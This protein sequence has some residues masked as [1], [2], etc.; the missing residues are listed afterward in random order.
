MC[1]AQRKIGESEIAFQVM[2]FSY[3][4]VAANMATN[5]IE[6]VKFLEEFRKK[7]QGRGFQVI[8]MGNSPNDFEYKKAVL[9]KIIAETQGKSLDTV[10][11]PKIAAGFIWRCIRISASIR[12]CF[13]IRGSKQHFAVM[14]GSQ[15]FAKEVHFMEKVAQIKKKLTEEG[16]IRDDDAGYI[17]W[18]HELGHL[19]HSEVLCAATEDSPRVADAKTRIHAEALKIALETHYGVP[20]GVGGDTLHDMF[21]PH[22]CNYHLWMRKVK[23]A[24]DPDNLSDAMLYISNK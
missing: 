2:G 24:F 16:L 18:T 21:G 19:G 7:V 11:D 8:L 23:K 10:E 4:M 15:M 14:G 1:E 13:R 12:E 6:D 9:K 5:N 3:A 20:S 17:C 22:A